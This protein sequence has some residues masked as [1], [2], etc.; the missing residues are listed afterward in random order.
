MVF[1]GSG[2]FG[3]CQVFPTAEM[4][5]NYQRDRNFATK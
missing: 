3:G 5:T 1:A 4:K 2:C